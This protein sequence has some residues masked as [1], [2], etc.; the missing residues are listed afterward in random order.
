MPKITAIMNTGRP[1]LCMPHLPGVHHF[2]YILESLSRQNFKDFEFVIADCMYNTRNKDYDWKN[3]KTDF[4]VYHIPVVHSLAHDMN[5]IAISGTKNAGIM[6]ASGEFLCF[7]DDCGLLEFNHFERIY[8]IFKR[9]GTFACP[10]RLKANT[11]GGF[12]Q[13]ARQIIFDRNPLDVYINCHDIYGFA[14]FSLEA[15]L[16]IGGIDEGYDWSMSMED[17]DT[18]RRLMAAGYKLSLHRNFYVK[19]QIHMDNNDRI[20]EPILKFKPILKC[21]PSYLFMKLDKRSGEDF[22]LANHRKL[23]S[24]E[25]SLLRPCYKM[26]VIDGN[27]VCRGSGRNQECEWYTRNPT[28]MEHPDI[29]IFLREQP[30]FDIRQKRDECL[31]NK[32]K[33]RVL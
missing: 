17:I 1:G 14:N 24:L 9:D 12:D 31:V 16:R 5:Y 25:L 6:Y 11:S 7:I 33:Y 23:T 19:E 20:F 15:A 10:M 13:D 18:G 28:N 8:E 3:K 22:I 21:N 30:V 32:E 29:E 26:E 2:D 4:P 27:A